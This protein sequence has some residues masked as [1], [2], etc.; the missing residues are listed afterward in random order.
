MA[1]RKIHNSPFTISLFLLAL[2]CAT[3]AWLLA[4]SSGPNSPATSQNNSPAWTNPDNMHAQDDT[5]ADGDLNDSVDQVN[6]GFAGLSGT[7]N[8]VLVEIDAYKDSTRNNNIT[9]NLL[10]VGTCTAKATAVL[11][12]SDTDT[13]QQLGGSTDTWACTALTPANV[14]STSFGVNILAT[15]SGGANP[16]AGTYHVDHVRITVYYTVSAPKKRRARVIVVSMV[17]GLGDAPLR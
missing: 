3:A 14:N 7:I 9:A 15:K 8:G 16:S 1:G 6:L 4:N 17:G 13:Y 2:L 12:T 11:P 5:P 10:N